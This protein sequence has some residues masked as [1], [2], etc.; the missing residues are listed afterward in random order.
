M[1]GSHTPVTSLHAERVWKFTWKHYPAPDFRL[2]LED[3]GATL[4]WDGIPHVYVYKLALPDGTVVT[5][6]PAI[7]SYAVAGRPGNYS[8]VAIGEFSRVLLSAGITV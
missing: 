1:A 7:N 4:R 2:R 5:L 3:S 6:P 8:I